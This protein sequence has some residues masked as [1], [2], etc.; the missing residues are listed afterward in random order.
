MDSDSGLVKKTGES[1]LISDRIFIDDAIIKEISKMFCPP[2]LLLLHILETDLKQVPDQ[3]HIHLFQHYLHLFILK[4]HQGNGIIIN[5]WLA[6]DLVVN[7][8]DYY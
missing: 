8:G 6:D 5:R 1:E 2:L 3:L 7:E 4:F